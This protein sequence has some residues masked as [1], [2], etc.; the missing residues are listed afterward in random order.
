M[1]FRPYHTTGGLL[2]DWQ[3]AAFQI[4]AVDRYVPLAGDFTGDG[5]CDV[6]LYE[7]A[8]GQWFEATSSGS[9][10]APSGSGWLGSWGANLTAYQPLT[11]DFNGDGKCDVCLYE[12]A[13]GGWFVATS[14][15]SAFVPAGTAWLG[16]WGANA[17]A[18]KAISGDFNGDG[19]CDVGLYEPAYGQWFVATSDGSAFTPTSQGWLANWGANATAYR[20]ITGKFNSGAAWDVGLYEPA[21]G[22]WFEASSTGS[23][24]SPSGSG[25]LGSWGAN[26]TAYQN[27]TGDFSGDGLYDVCL[28]EMATGG[29]FVATSTG[30]AFTPASSAWMGPWGANATAYRA[31]SGDFTGDGKC[32]VVLYEPAYGQWFE[33]T[34]S[35]SGFSPSSSGWLGGWG[36]GSSARPA[37]PD[38]GPPPITN[39]S[40]RLWAAPNPAISSV[41]ISFTLP[42]A[43]RVSISIF[44]VSGRE[45]ATFAEGQYGVGE[46]VLSWNRNSP[47]GGRVARGVYF[48]A[49][50][51]TLHTATVKVVVLD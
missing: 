45:V 44:D 19:K 17:T 38:D 5:K 39:S 10:F 18:Y 14:N 20:A 37:P 34:S 26:A 43:D 36:G 4:S 2:E 50:R 7:P 42:V 3:G 33:A 47:R 27:L 32:D 35:G 28:Y 22:Q 49:F 24:F 8:N 23:S 30:S 31:L 12:A 48:I 21:Y 29:W 46:H 16:G 11:G 6:V 51:S 15:G 1:Y 41:N 13:T 25:W 40:F 9:S